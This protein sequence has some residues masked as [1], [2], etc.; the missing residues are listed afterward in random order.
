MLHMLQID[1]TRKPVWMYNDLCK[2]QTSAVEWVKVGNKSVTVFLAVDFPTRT[3][4]KKAL[5]GTTKKA[6]Q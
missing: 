1:Y 3:W 5:V 2:C 4:K 6:Q